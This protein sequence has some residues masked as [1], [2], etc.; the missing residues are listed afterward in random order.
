MPYSQ[1][2]MVRVA[3]A[4][5]NPAL[6]IET[7]KA[8]MQSIL[9]RAEKECADFICFPEG[10]LTGYYAD[11]NLARQNSLEVGGSAFEEWLD[12][13][14]E[15]S[16]TIIVGF[17]EREGHHLFDSAA[18]VE[19]G[20]L[21]GVQRKHNL[22]HGYFT[23]GTSFSPLNSKGVA[24]GVVICLDTN[25]F[26]PSRLLALQGASILF[27]PMCNRVPNDHPY[28]KRPPYYSHFVAR[29]FENRCWLVTADWIWPK[30]SSLI[31][32]GHSVIYDPDGQEVARSEEGA[33]QLL[34]FD[35][36]SGSLV[37]NKGKR[38]HGSQI[39]VQELAK[40]SLERAAW[41]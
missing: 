21:L 4:Q 9:L 15:S 33:E 31:C 12:L 27:S 10:F 26:E 24:F 22:Y 35:I 14:K 25:Y 16:S 32:P 5:L 6:E 13:L 40:L 8:Q 37:Q 39:L 38:V 29:S 36:P 30:D 28:A 11:E 19:N 2:V 18:I 7:R 3:A 17:N 1:A 23:S 34:T 20:I 41:K